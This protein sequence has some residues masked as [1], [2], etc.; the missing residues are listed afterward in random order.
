MTVE[1]AQATG[2]PRCS[3]IAVTFAT[4]SLRTLSP[5]VPSMSPPVPDT[6]DAAP[7]FVPGAMYARFA[8]SVMNVPALAARPPAGATHT[9]TGTSASRNAAVIRCVASRLPPGV[10]SST[11][12]AAAPS[13]TAC[14][15]PS[16]RYVASTPSTVPVAVS[17]TTCGCAPRAIEAVATSRTPSS[18]S[19]RARRIRRERVEWSM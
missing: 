8:A 2:R 12:T 4:A 19:V 18:A 17:K 6:G 11:T 15:I 5:S 3:A 16:S 14:S 9:M 1:T 10:L 7:M 13:V